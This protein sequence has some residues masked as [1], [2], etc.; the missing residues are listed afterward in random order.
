M[1]KDNFSV[2]YK[3][4]SYTKEKKLG[5][6]IIM[7]ILLALSGGVNIQLARKVSSLRSILDWERRLSI[8]VS[9]PPLLAHTLDG[10]PATISFSGRDLPTI[11][12][13]FSPQ[14][15]WCTRNLDNIKTI[16]SSLKGKYGFIGLSMSDSLLERYIASND[17]SFPV[18]KKPDQ[19]SVTDFR[20][21]G[22]PITLVISPDGKV[23]KNW[24]GAYSEG[25]K[26][27]VE[28]FFGITLPG[29]KMEND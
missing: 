8:G 23:L 15:V 26:R 24:S 17:L 10:T 25:Q 9:A 3:L 14:C 13:V 2:I 22:T 12:Y 28:H 7:S 5:T 18:Y 20:L 11:L 19:R 21:S 27:D 29:V 1:F 6:I 16:E 4:R